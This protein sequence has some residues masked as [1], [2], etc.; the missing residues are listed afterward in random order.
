M[1]CDRIT[2]LFSKLLPFVFLFVFFHYNFRFSVFP[3]IQAKAVKV[4]E[5]KTC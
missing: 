3:G 5:T 1:T 2:S 4:S